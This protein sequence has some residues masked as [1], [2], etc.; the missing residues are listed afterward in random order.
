[1]L[2]LASFGTGRYGPSLEALRCSALHAGGFGRVLLFGAD[3]VPPFEGHGDY[4][5]KPEV[6]RLAMARCAP[7]DWLVYADATT[8]FERPFG[9]RLAGVA[10]PALLFTLCGARHTQG[11]WTKPGCLEAMRV[12]PAEAALPQVNAA[13]QAYRVGPE[14]AAFVAEWAA[15]CGRPEAVASDPA[16]PDHRHDQSVLSVLA[17]RDP[18]ARLAPDVTQHGPAPLI[19]HHR[20]LMGPMR[21]LTVV[22]PTTGDLPRLSRAMDSV[23]AQRVVLLRHLVVCDGPAATRAT[24]PLR[25]AYLDGVP[26]TW[27]DLPFPTG[28]GRWN[29]HR[30]YGAACF[31][32][33]AA[34]AAGPS[35]LVAFL[36]EDN[37]YGEDHLPALLDRL[38]DGGLDAAFSLRTIRDRE[39]GA[40][41]CRDECESLGDLA[42]ASVGGYH[43]VDTSCWLLG[44][45]AAAATAGCWDAR[46]RQAGR[47]EVDRALTAALLDGWRVG[48]VARHSLNYTAGSGQ[49]SAPAS[50]FLQAN[51]VNRWA[52]ADRPCLYLFH[53]TADRTAEFFAKQFDTAASHLL[54]EWNMNQPRAL[55]RRF[56]LVDGYACGTRIPRGATVLVHLC[57]PD[58]LPLALLTQR[59]DL[60]RLLYTAESPNIRHREQWRAG[61]LRRVADVVLTYWEPVL[62]DP[63]VPTVAFPHQCHHLDEDNPADRAQF[64][65]NTGEPGSVGVV[66][67]N[68][69]GL[70]AYTIDA[71]RLHCLDGMRQVWA[72]RLGEQGLRVTVHGRGWKDNGPWTVGGSAGKYADRLHAVDILQRHSAVL[73]VENCDADGYVSEKAYDALLAGAVPIFY[74][75]R[76]AALPREAC[77][78]LAEE[79]V[80][81]VTAEAIAAK[82]DAVY[83]LREGILAATSAQRYADAVWDACQ[84]SRSQAV[85][86]GDVQA[87][88]VGPGQPPTPTSSAG[89]GSDSLTDGS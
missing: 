72:R 32:A 79:P 42:P 44:H 43:L 28:R 55:H 19:N 21:T 30:I 78:N 67:E 66:L 4:A 39:T 54:D 83:R 14:A 53:M 26:V 89:G 15:W 33:P 77:F 13:V 25:G 58:A 76:A 59:T 51:A 60:R 45:A 88:A 20:V 70:A 73:V 40:A 16:F 87:S 69:S 63:E 7:G 48:G 86:P 11:A 84:L 68:R 2:V 80:T 62:A 29:G 56:N 61:F 22:T 57:H 85:K 41:L 6:V 3:D 75:G 74:N 31:L 18:R 8:L 65:T 10:E 1:M 82:R 27:L 34:H 37:W 23:Q 35:E 64:R 50:Y 52:M 17:H 9:P 81:A 46:A 24:L 38:L 47:E 5:W 12:T 36:D 71:H 49:L